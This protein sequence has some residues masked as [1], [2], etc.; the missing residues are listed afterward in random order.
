MVNRVRKFFKSA[1]KR[2][3][4]F[5]SPGR[6]K[7]RRV[8]VFAEKKDRQ[9]TSIEEYPETSS[10][11][12]YTTSVSPKKEPLTERAAPSSTKSQQ[13]I[14]PAWTLD[15]FEV[16][17]LPGKSR[18][19]DFA[20]DLRIMRGIAA[21]KFNYCTPIQEKALPPTLNGSDVIGRA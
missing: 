4:S 13:T 6:N 10:P 9:I 20:I 1:T 5:A 15:D 11:P 12:E 14:K 2:F 17:P 16:I 3:G 18:F 21:E 8:H 19:H 7:K